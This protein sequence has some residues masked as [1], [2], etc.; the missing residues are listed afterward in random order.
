MCIIQNINILFAYVYL[1]K[2]G[3]IHLKKMMIVV[4]YMQAERLKITNYS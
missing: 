4:L 1:Y 2:G 3:I